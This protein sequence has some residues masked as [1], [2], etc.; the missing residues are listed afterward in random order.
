MRS[1]KL[2]TVFGIGMII[3]SIPCTLASVLIWHLTVAIEEGRA[4][5]QDVGF[6]VI[7][8]AMMSYFT[9]LIAVGSCVAGLLYFAYAVLKKKEALK[10]WH[11]FGIVYS[12]LQVTTAVAYM[13]TR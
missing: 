2:T 10:R 6:D 1:S 4:A 13:S 7:G 12:I 9:F 8:A 11:S 3:G 5:G